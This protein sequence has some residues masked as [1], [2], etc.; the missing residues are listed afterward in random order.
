MPHFEYTIHPDPVFRLSVMWFQR[1][2]PMLQSL[3]SPGL[4]A[5]YI[6]QGPL[7]KP[8]KLSADSVNSDLDEWKEL[9]DLLI[10]NLGFPERDE[11]DDI[12]R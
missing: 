5:E 8:C 12:Q 4:R 6:L 7:V 3:K 9:G 2:G 1:I 11:L 10:R